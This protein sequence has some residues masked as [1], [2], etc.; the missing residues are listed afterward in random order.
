MSSHVTNALEWD[1][2]V[3][4]TLSDMVTHRR[5]ANSNNTTLESPP[6][7]TRDRRRAFSRYVLIARDGRAVRVPW[8]AIVWITHRLVIIG[9]RCAKK[10][11]D[12]EYVNREMR[13][14][15][16]W[17]NDLHHDRDHTLLLT[18]L[19][20][21]APELG[22]SESRMCALGVAF[23]RDVDE[24]GFHERACVAFAGYD[25]LVRF[26]QEQ[27]SQQQPPVGTKRPSSS[28]D[29]ADHIA[30]DHGHAEKMEE[31][32]N[33]GEERAPTCVVCLCADPSAHPR[34][35]RGTCRV[36]TCATCWRDSRGLCALCDRSSINASYQC[37]ACGKER[38]LT[39][40]G[41]SCTLCNEAS[42]CDTCHVRFGMC[43][44]CEVKMEL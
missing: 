17:A 11:G 38:R 12:G 26:R 44:G 34:C 6:P 39:R 42:L 24:K 35:R 18:K 3:R 8:T 23:P 9:L 36:A 5:G 2:L 7:L 14:V 15:W 40:Y 33:D 41:Y 30:D 32:E 31:D 21:D 20:D 25:R 37:S 27:Q 1:G 29:A 4:R 28:S 10:G 16:Y 22:W 43:T 13:H 19:I